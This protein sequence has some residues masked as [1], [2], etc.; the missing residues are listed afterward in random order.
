MNKVSHTILPPPAHSR[1]A[2]RALKLLPIAALLAAGAAQAQVTG[3]AFTGS[4]DSSTTTCKDVFLG[5]KTDGTCGTPPCYS[6]GSGMTFSQNQGGTVVT[7]TEDWGSAPYP[8]DTQINP[9]AGSGFTPAPP[10][11]LDTTLPFTLT[12][13]LVDGSN[14]FSDTVTI[15]G[16]VNPKILRT[17]TATATE[18]GSIACT[19]DPVPVGDTV[20]CTATANQ[21]V[22]LETLEISDGVNPPVSCT[23]SP[24]SLA[25]VKGNVTATAT[26]KAPPTPTPDPTP[27]P[28]PSGGG[29]SSSPTMGELGLLLSG[30]ALA[31][32]AAPALRRR[33]KQGKK[34]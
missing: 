26:F 32:A 5:F 18:G 9:L 8:F 24:C 27:T 13:T 21:G 25:G 31:G 14:T 6:T 10:S 30:L 7:G 23:T 1:R 11:D 19:P 3:I 15:S 20:E 22:A 12:M 28:T 16:C 33:E 2:A 29:D 34:G 17:I 4:I